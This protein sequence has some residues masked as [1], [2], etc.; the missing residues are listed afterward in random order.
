MVSSELDEILQEDGA[1]RAAKF[2]KEEARNWRE[3]KNSSKSSRSENLFNNPIPRG[4][5][6]AVTF[7]FAMQTNERRVSARL[8]PRL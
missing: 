6:S 1:R 5:L 4:Y 2:Q 7:P 8:F 3:V